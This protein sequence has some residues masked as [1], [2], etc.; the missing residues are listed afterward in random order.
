MMENPGAHNL[1]EARLQIVHL[2]DGKLVDLEIVQVVFS[3]Q[4]LSTTYT[5]CAEVDADNLELQAIVRHAWPLE[6][7]RSRR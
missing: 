1:I 7:F 3:L 2:L 5:C 4:L 6:M